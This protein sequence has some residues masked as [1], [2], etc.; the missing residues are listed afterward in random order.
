MSTLHLA[1]ELVRLLVAQ[2]RERRRPLTA[3]EL[4]Q[5]MG[6]PA[7]ALGESLQVISRH[8]EQLKLPDLSSLVCREES[9]A[10]DPGWRPELP[11]AE[12]LVSAWEE[13]ARLW[14]FD[15]WLK[16]EEVIIRLQRLG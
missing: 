11:Q 4:G 7:H 3:A 16:Y 2:A 5:A 10:P 15:E 8:C 9:G 1:P 13:Q 12:R 14:V 6:H